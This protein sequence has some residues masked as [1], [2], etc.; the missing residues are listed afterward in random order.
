MANVQRKPKTIVELA[1]NAGD[2]S[3]L[4]DALTAAELVNTLKGDG[5]FTVFAPTNEAF[6]ALPKGTLKSLLKGTNRSRLESLLKHHVVPKRVMANDVASMSSI[7]MLDG[8]SVPVEKEGNV[9]H[10][11]GAAIRRTNLEAE[12]GIVHVIDRVMMPVEA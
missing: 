11:G 5:P 8:E 9:I 12:N 2:F 7:E 4:V 6:E 1:S 3:T 10:V